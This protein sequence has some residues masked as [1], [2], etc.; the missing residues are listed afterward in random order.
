MTEKRD[1]M[2]RLRDVRMGKLYRD[3][4]LRG[5]LATPIL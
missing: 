3:D 1:L 4:V 2:L 5:R